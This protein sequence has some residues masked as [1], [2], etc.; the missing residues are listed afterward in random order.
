MSDW[1]GHI[2]G[3][4]SALA[5]LD[6]SQPGDAMLPLFGQSFWAYELSR[7]V[8]NGSVPVSRV[9]DMTTRVVAAWYQM[10]QDKG[11]LKLNPSYANT[12][13]RKVSHRRISQR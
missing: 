3:V 4:A 2:S 6:M 11:I 10:G 13:G 8:L 9:N 1:F 5:G 12:D 7:A